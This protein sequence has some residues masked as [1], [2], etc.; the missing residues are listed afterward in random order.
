MDN[1]SMARKILKI[2]DQVVVLNDLVEKR[3]TQEAA[4]EINLTTRQVRNK[5]KAFKSEGKATV[6]FYKDTGRSSKKKW[7]PNEVAF[8]IELLKGPVWY[9]FGPNICC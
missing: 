1:Y 2:A 6:R 8:A 9:D 7:S 3:I 4:A 5:L